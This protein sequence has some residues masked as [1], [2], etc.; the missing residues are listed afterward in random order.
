MNKFVVLVLAGLHSPCCCWYILCMSKQT[1]CLKN[2]CVEVPM[3][4]ITCVASLAPGLWCVTQPVSGPVCVLLITPHRLLGP[5]SHQSG[6]SPENSV[7]LPNNYQ[8]M[9]PLYIHYLAN[10]I[11]KHERRHEK[12]I[13]RTDARHLA[14]VRNCIASR[15]TTLSHRPTHCACGAPLSPAQHRRPQN[16]GTPTSKLHL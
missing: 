4:F 3:V 10:L 11:H 8:G 13:L 14:P 12:A 1:L 15:C 9:H 6:S 5:P 7:L 16:R 2:L